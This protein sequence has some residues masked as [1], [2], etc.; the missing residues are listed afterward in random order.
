MA[1]KKEVKKVVRKVINVKNFE[2]LSEEEQ[3]KILDRIIDGIDE[4][5]GT[6]TP[7]DEDE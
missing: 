7:E 1:D 2:D 6:E 3:D 5:A 4:E